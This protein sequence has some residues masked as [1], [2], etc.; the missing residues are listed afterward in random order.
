[1]AGVVRNYTSFSAA[2]RDFEDARVFAGIHFRFADADATEFGHKIAQYIL[3]N[4]CLP[5][6]GQKNG[7]LR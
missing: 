1:M 6:H 3:S 5:L 2:E 4:A 7:Q